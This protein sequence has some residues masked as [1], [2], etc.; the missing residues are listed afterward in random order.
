MA[1]I[2]GQPRHQMWSC[3]GSVVI[4]IYSHLNVWTLVGVCISWCM[5]SYVFF[6][7][8]IDFLCLLQALSIIFLFSMLSE[9]EHFFLKFCTCQNHNSNYFYPCISGNLHKYVES[10]IYKHQ[11]NPLQIGC[12]K[13]GKLTT[14][15]KSLICIRP[16]FF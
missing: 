9:I 14:L 1:W 2:I 4:L 16:V 6:N 13:T 10:C 3:L 15:K 12:N 7:L 8:C 5:I 11:L